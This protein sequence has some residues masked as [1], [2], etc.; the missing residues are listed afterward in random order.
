MYWLSFVAYYLLWKAYNHVS[1]LRA[2]ALMSAEVRPE[3]F[4]ILV[5]DIPS[6]PEGQTRKELVDSYFK[7]IYADA[8]YKSMVVTNN[9]EVLD[10]C[11]SHLT[12]YH[13]FTASVFFLNLIVTSLFWQYDFLI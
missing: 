11:D 5:R 4:T 9:R 10:S 8:Y 3:Q 1:D 13:F 2:A 12:I 6:P 7:A